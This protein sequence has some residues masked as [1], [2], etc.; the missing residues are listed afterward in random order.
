M[1]VTEPRRYVIRRAFVAPLGLVI[2]LMGALLVVSILHGQPLAKVVFLLVFALPVAL[3]FVESAFRRIE[4]DADGVTAFRLFRSRRLDF[5][6]ITALETVQ[7][8]SRVFLTL[9]AGDDEFLIISNGYSDFPGL[10]QALIAA[11]PPSVVT[12]ESRQLAVKP[13][14]RHADL[15]MVWFMIAALV[16][17]LIAQFR[18]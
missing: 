12:D 5:T 4:I 3:L 11:L 7:V 15:V 2:L 9:A 18:S 8:R 14:R 1:V 17:V 13:P 10:V 6:Q 16:Y